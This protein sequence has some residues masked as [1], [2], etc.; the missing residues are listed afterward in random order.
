MRT[1][2]NVTRRDFLKSAGGLVLAVSLPQSLAQS[3]PGRTVPAGGPAAAA[4]VPNAFIRIGADNTVTVVVKHL[5]MGQGTYTGLPTLV[6]EELDADWAQIRAVGAP[7]D[8]QQYNNLFWGQRRARAA[9]PRSRTRTSRC[10]R[11]APPRAM[12]VARRRKVESAGLGNPFRG[13]V[14]W[15][16]R[17]DVRQLAAM[18]RNRKCPP[19]SSSRTPRI[20]STSASPR[21]AP[22]RARSRTERHSSRRT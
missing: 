16:D 6:A 18:R 3:G 9:A 19:M 8:A 15:K 4:F 22:T 1:I 7:A 10:A 2:L 20:S 13:V 21:G 12:L 17:G 14:S 5:E 11:P